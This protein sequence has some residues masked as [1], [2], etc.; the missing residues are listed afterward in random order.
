MLPT[1]GHCFR[2]ISIAVSYRSPLMMPCQNAS[3]RRCSSYERAKR[4]HLL[5]R[6]LRHEGA[7]S[8][9]VRQQP[10]SSKTTSDQPR[11]SLQAA[12]SPFNYKYKLSFKTSEK[13]RCH[14]TSQ[15]SATQTKK[16]SQQ[17]NADTVQDSPPPKQ[18]RSDSTAI[19]PIKPLT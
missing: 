14:Q 5:W 7:H 13:A 18:I 10:I 8:P 6:V 9:W 1:R 19:R 15:A 17:P 16:P 4:L 12:E 11:K 3:L 2:Q